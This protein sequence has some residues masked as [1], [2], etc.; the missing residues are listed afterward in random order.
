MIVLILFSVYENDSPV[1]LSSL[2][3][4]YT[5]VI[6]S[7]GGLLEILP[8]D[9]LFL[10]SQKFSSEEHPIITQNYELSHF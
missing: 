5:C 8:L 2:V 10:N 6:H 4:N 3:E 1:F 7:S 9:F